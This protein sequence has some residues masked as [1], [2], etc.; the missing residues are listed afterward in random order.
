M[1]AINWGRVFLGGIVAGILINISEFILNEKVL[2][3]DWETTMKAMNKT[4]PAGGS[5]MVVWIIFG[6]VVGIAA[7]WLYA[8]IRP[9]YGAGPGTAVKAGIAVWF[10]MS[11]LSAIAMTNMGLFP[12]NVLTFS[13]IWELVQDIIA[14][15]LGAWLYKE[16]GGL[17]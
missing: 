2:K 13:C 15:L 1:K 9:R 10:F 3:S 17:A 8:A 7:V 4:M 11:F 5:T 16:E 12:T 14:T 6:F